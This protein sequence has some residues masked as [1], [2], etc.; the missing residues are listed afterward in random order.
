MRTEKLTLLRRL[1]GVRPPEPG[2]EELPPSGESQPDEPL[3]LELLR[4]E[5]EQGAPRTCRGC[6]G[7]MVRTDHTPR[8]TVA[9]L[10]RM[11]PSREMT[12]ETG[13]VQ[14]HLNVSAFL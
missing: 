4:L 14:L 12:V 10:M 13:P 9:E 6:G 11:P 3:D 2:E 8:P 5:A 7:E 1:L